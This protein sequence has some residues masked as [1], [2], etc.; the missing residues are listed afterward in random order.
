MW[1]KWPFGKSSWEIAT[2][3]VILMIELLINGP[4]ILGY[5]R[6]IANR[7]TIPPPTAQTYTYTVS[8]SLHF[9]DLEDDTRISIHSITKMWVEGGRAGWND[10][11][12]YI[13]D[14]PVTVPPCQQ[15]FVGGLWRV[16]NM[17][18]SICP[19]PPPPPLRSIPSVET[20]TQ[21]HL[22]NC[23]AGLQ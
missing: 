18:A 13:Q 22:Y 14:K 7:N 1:H 15:I 23:T 20:I 6:F 19:P 8:V 11:A 10:R 5:S 3:H 2:F 17:R 12:R 21:R 9:H 16:T 4:H